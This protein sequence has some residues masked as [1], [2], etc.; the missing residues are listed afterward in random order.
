MQVRAQDTAAYLG[1]SSG[2][3]QVAGTPFTVTV[4][5]F[6]ANGSVATDYTGT[7]HFTSSDSGSGV[8]LPS[9]YAFQAGDNGVKSFSVTLVTAGSQSVT[10]TD[11]V[12][13][14]ITGSQTGIT[15]TGGSLDH[16]TAS[17]SPASVAAG[18]TSTGTATAFDAQNNNLG[19]VSASWSIPAGGDGGSWSGNVYTSHTVGIY[20]V[21][22]SYSGKTATT[23]L[24]VTAGSLDHFVVG[25][26]G[27]ATVG[28]PFTLSVTAK[29]AYGNTITS[30]SSSVGLSASTGTISPTSTG[31]SGWSN[32][33]WSSASV[34]LTAVGSITITANDG[35]GHTGTASVTVSVGSVD[36]IVVTPS[37][38]TVTAGGQQ[39][40][41]STAYD[42][43][44]NVIGTVTSSSDLGYFRVVLVVLGFSLLVLTHL[45]TLVLRTVTAVYSRRGI[46]P[47]R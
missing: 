8:S 20:T 22:A 47:L 23:S 6:Y 1:V 34:T 27:S 28:T 29:D 10:A 39:A 40:F 4:T 16:I 25:A 19:V 21:Q 18:S 36:H 2:T 37:S 9:N 26:P 38:A 42:Q 15:V 41:F 32:G 45:G 44:N 17:V 12:I 5:A 13:S 30:Y 11:T 33:V 14:S 35:S 43:Y 46:Q 24:T 31:T 7:I 3:S